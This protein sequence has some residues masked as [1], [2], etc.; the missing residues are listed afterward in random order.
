MIVKIKNVDDE[1][2][3][4]IAIEIFS[5]FVEAVSTL[6]REFILNESEIKSTTTTTNNN[7]SILN[8]NTK[9][10]LMSAAVT[11][12]PTNENYEDIS[13][14]TLLNLVIKNMI[15]D[16][17][18]ELSGAM[19]IVNLLKLLI[20][21]ENMLSAINVSVIIV[22]VCVFEYNFFIF[23]FFKESRKVRIFSTFL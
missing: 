6:V 23:M 20:D 2:V 7:N 22:S 16:P 14:F 3:N 5:H 10:L 8:L 19:Q 9:Q 17:D 13:D 21:P 4:A 15:N 12:T 11:T 1:K 18:Q